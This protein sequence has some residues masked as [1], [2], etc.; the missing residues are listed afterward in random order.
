[1]YIYLP[2]TSIIVLLIFSHSCISYIVTHLPSISTNP[3][4]TICE[5]ANQPLILT[6][7]IVGIHISMFHLTAR[8][9]KQEIKGYE[10]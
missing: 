10:V 8:E 7:D 6:L 2:Q 5:L 1:M 3:P 4:L 9:R